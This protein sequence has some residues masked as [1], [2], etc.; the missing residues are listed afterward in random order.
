MTPDRMRRVVREVVA[1]STTPSYKS[2]KRAL[3]S[4]KD[5]GEDVYERFKSIVSAELEAFARASTARPPGREGAELGDAYEAISTLE[6]EMDDLEKAYVA[7]RDC[8]SSSCVRT[9][10]LRELY[11][12]LGRDVDACAD[13]LDRLLLAAPS[14]IDK[15]TTTGSTPTTCL[16][17]DKEPPRPP[18]SPERSS[19]VRSPPSTR[20]NAFRTPSTSRSETITKATRGGRI[21]DWLNDSVCFGYTFVSTRKKRNMQV[22][23]FLSGIL[24]PT[25]RSSRSLRF[26]VLRNDELAFYPDWTRAKDD[27][28]FQTA[29]KFEHVSVQ[30]IASVEESSKGSKN[31]FE[32]ETTAGDDLVYVLDV[33][34]ETTLST[35]AQQ[36]SSSSPNVVSSSSPDRRSQPPAV[37]L[38]ATS[39][40]TWIAALR[41]VV[42]QIEIGR[43][44]MLDLLPMGRVEIVTS[45][46]DESTGNSKALYEFRLTGTHLLL[47]KADEGEGSETAT[48]HI[49]L[50]YVTL[51]V[52]SPDR[53]ELLLDQGK[54]SQ[55]IRLRFHSDA[56]LDIVNVL[57]SFRQSRRPAGFVVSSLTFHP[58]WSR[59]SGPPEMWAS[60]RELMNR[61]EQMFLA[62]KTYPW[63]KRMLVF[64]FGSELF[65]KCKPG[66][67]SLSKSVDR[68]R[69]AA[70]SCPRLASIAASDLDAFTATARS[71]SS[72][73]KVAA[74]ARRPERV[75]FE[76]RIDVSVVNVSGEEDDHVSCATSRRF[77]RLMR[78]GRL[79]CFDRRPR[80]P[81][82]EPNWTCDLPSARVQLDERETIVRVQHHLVDGTIVLHFDGDRKRWTSFV[83]TA[84][85]LG[86]DPFARRPHVTLPRDA[87]VETAIV[88]IAST[89]GRHQV[90]VASDNDAEGVRRALALDRAGSSLRAN[91]V[92]TDALVEGVS[93]QT[94]VFALRRY[95]IPSVRDFDE[96]RVL[97]LPQDSNDLAT[98]FED[99]SFVDHAPHVFSTIRRAFGVSDEAF[100]RSFAEPVRGGGE[101]DGKSKMAFYRSADD[102]YIIKQVKKSEFRQLKSMLL[103]YYEHVLRNPD[104]LLSRFYGL[105]ELRDGTS[106]YG[107]DRI[108]VVMNNVCLGRPYVSGRQ[109][110]RYDLKGSA[111]GRRV[112]P[113][114]I[115][116]E[117]KTAKDLNW[118][119]SR[120]KI[121]VGRALR[122]RL[123]E[124]ITRDAKML[125]RNGIIDYSL[126]VGVANGRD[127][128]R[129]ITDEE[130]TTTYVVGRSNWNAFH[131]GMRSRNLRKE[132][133]VRGRA[134]V[135]TTAGSTVAG[136]FR[137]RAGLR[138]LRESADVRGTESP[139]RE[140]LETQFR[141][142][143]AGRNVEFEIYYMGVRT[144]GFVQS[145]DADAITT[146][147][148]R[149]QI[150]DF[151]QS[152]DNW[153]VVEHTAKTIV[154]GN[155]NDMSAVPPA[156]YFP[157]FCAFLDAQISE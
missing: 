49:W 66:V 121:Y 155:S 72:P 143:T 96:S 29:D 100:M 92:V 157:R 21:E 139:F 144:Y 68:C 105:I 130:E 137:R 6:R 118:T 111:R 62:G 48:R 135:E 52:A 61:A 109:M 88:D 3:I 153:K 80:R 122:A 83:E 140:Y 86:N 32:I 37:S 75:L 19:P 89:C 104:T 95:V 40:E 8:A 43:Q 51:Y 69:D 2:A 78:D 112:D 154:G 71:S 145:P 31:A 67:K 55:V 119:E 64:E 12:R 133:V 152:Y 45:S 23:S 147:S 87:D 44:M 28:Y 124:Q 107:G 134:D 114:S 42:K 110:I 115:E 113:A 97:Y 10:Y 125:T 132:E 77:V 20:T 103:D 127:V 24:S 94:R 146:T 151:L 15:S 76:R 63:S 56:F 26:C 25:S 22:K 4:R 57:E 70:K 36:D 35:I 98:S 108:L 30:K 14:P 13:R 7:S 117:N 106:R 11:D 1:A 141:E 148:P 101:G 90:R 47:S 34:D 136:L 123:V 18:P 65:D 129:E 84:M 27:Y 93:V 58:R 39:R 50:E 150:I 91:R 9:Q 142:E 79:E 53:A 38:S 17:L 46:K 33:A 99:V 116:R 54:T 5:V 16:M 131:G 60:E 41:R 81:R 126:L 149:A 120:R 128:A 59:A 73:D 82:S 138:V 102:M 85:T 74:R 156:K